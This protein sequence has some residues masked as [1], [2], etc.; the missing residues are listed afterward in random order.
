M[1]RRLL[2]GRAIQIGLL[3]LLPVLILSFFALGR[4]RKTP[5]QPGL[6]PVPQVSHT[7]VRPQGEPE[8]TPT[9]P[10]PE[11]QP[12]GAQS[13]GSTPAEKA[14]PG[15][16]PALA[17]PP[18]TQPPDRSS[19]PPQPQAQT[20]T[21][22]PPQTAA[23]V[24]QTLGEHWDQAKPSNPP[25]LKVPTAQKT[26]WRQ[27]D[28]GQSEEVDVAK[29]QKT[30]EIASMRKSPQERAKE[31][32]KERTRPTAPPKPSSPPPAQAEASARLAIMDQSGQPELGKAYRDVLGV[33]GFHV[34]QLI[35]KTPSTGATQVFYK[36]DAEP[37]ARRIFD[38]LPGRKT[39][40]LL[41]GASPFDVV[42]V[43]QR[44][45]PRRFG[46]SAGQ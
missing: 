35:R 27:L 23:P 13:T 31:K 39:I 8:T 19:A 38:R 32:E 37:L 2:S 29:G 46:A 41:S 36:P 26:P 45:A 40:G 20:G 14:N 16:S 1:L 4:L 10:E 5:D 11:T 43:V 25:Q 22:A 3:V 21:N 44:G 34:T 9:A 28:L 33:M 15:Q 24:W 6:K 30:L 7:L 18:Q 42:I 17:P 12:A